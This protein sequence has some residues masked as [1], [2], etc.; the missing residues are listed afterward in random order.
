MLKNPHFRRRPEQR[1]TLR[2]LLAEDDPVSMYAARRVL[3][4]AGHSVT[5][6][7]D[8]GQVLELLRDQDFDLVLMDVQMPIM[9]G[10]VATAMIRSDPSLGPKSG[11]P[12]IAMTAYAMDGDREKFLAC[13]MD[14]YM[15]KPLD[16]SKL[17]QV[18]QNIFAAEAVANRPGINPEREESAQESRFEES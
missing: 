10:V 11:I 7:T 9:D 13:G 15:A 1:A 16:S 14:D 3:E 4:K 5:P 18:I 12:I 17:C 6:A 8:G 2:I